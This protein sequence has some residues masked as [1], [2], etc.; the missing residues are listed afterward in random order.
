[1]TGTQQ[2]HT[3]GPQ[4]H[5]P[6]CLAPPS[7]HRQPS[8]WLTVAALLSTGHRLRGLS[9]PHT[10]THLALKITCTNITLIY[11]DGNSL[12]QGHTASKR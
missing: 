1:M 8:R 4:G 10:R 9:T 6:G 12:A 7:K 2:E 3:K 11:R 5:C